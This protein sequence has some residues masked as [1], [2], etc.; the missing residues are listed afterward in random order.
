[1]FRAFDTK[2][3]S[4]APA[5]SG[6][7]T[8]ALAFVSDKALGGA[9]DAQR[10]IDV[11]LGLLCFGKPRRRQLSQIRWL[12]VL[13]KHIDWRRKSLIVNVAECSEILLGGNSL[14]SKVAG[15]CD[16]GS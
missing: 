14:R 15:N 1:M 5:E 8:L 9:P 2:V 11:T 16:I 3:L 10:F 12:D 4:A 13:G 6:A 7:N